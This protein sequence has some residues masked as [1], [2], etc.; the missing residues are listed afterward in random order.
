MELRKVAQS[1]GADL[2]HRSGPYRGGDSR[3]DT[4]L[5][6]PSDLVRPN[7]A[8]H[9]KSLE[10]TKGKKG[11]TYTLRHS[12]AVI[13]GELINPDSLGPVRLVFS[14]FL[15]ANG[16][17][18]PDS[19]IEIKTSHGTFFDGV[20]DPRV[21]KFKV[22]LPPFS[23]QAYFSL[24]LGDRPIIQEYLITPYDSVMIG[25]DLQRFNT[26]FSGPQSDF[27]E[28]QYL[29][30]REIQQATFASPRMVV[31]SNR[32]KFLDREDYREQWKEASTQFGPKLRI[33]QYGTEA[34][35]DDLSKLNLPE[36]EIPGMSVLL[37]QK[38]KLSSYQFEILRQDILGT[39]YG[40]ILS[41]LRRYGWLL[42]KSKNDG[43][44]LELL[45]RELPPILGKLKSQIDRMTAQNSTSGALVFYQEWTKMESSRSG[46]SFEVLAD[47]GFP[48]IIR[49]QLLYAY[50]MEQVSRS[51][52]PEKFLKD[53][54][55]QIRE[56]ELIQPLIQI[57]DRLAPGQSLRYAEFYSLDGQKIAPT[58]LRGKP[59]LLY[60]YFSTCTHSANFFNRV[61]API[62]GAGL[63]NTDLQIVAVSV[64]N[65]PE[66]WKENIDTYSDPS[67]RNLRLP[68]KQW[69]TWLDHYLISAYPR[70]MLLNE[71]GEVISVWVPGTTESSFKNHLSDLLK[72]DSN[73]S[74]IQKP[75]SE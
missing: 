19:T 35:G 65:D 3:S 75:K 29:I 61:L 17:S 64:D 24:F 62:Q 10:P 15:K 38:G 68:S 32:E 73:P 7:S 69:R 36:S 6:Y 2:L 50:A 20:L 37:E 60:F 43:P 14:H 72:S 33:L 12:P 55:G 4:Y 56:P 57:A 58:E 26:V 41:S 51:P 71:K 22:N 74:P 70:T 9:T 25:I 67:L 18:L 27:M 1:P 49:D 28:T 21:R 40:Q 31:Q 39:Y 34:I 48:D 5:I 30:K 23:R 42:A 63:E 59:T 11:T 46:R 53:I 54:I 44:A 47:K 45:D 13:Y 66:L 16:Q 52:N 8:F